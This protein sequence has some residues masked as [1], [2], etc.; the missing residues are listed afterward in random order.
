MSIDKKDKKGKE[1]KIG[2]GGLLCDP[3]QKRRRREKT[4]TVPNTF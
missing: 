3:V 4:I 2:K 1:K